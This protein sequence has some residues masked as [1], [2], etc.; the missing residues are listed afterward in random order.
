[1]NDILT[2]L[3]PDL[4]ELAWRQAQYPP[5][6]PAQCRRVAAEKKLRASLT[7][8]QWRLYLALEAEIN[9][10]MAMEEDCLLE[11]SLRLAQALYR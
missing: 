9:R 8:K 11:Q 10:Q 7:K 1:M 6:Y 2:Q 4:G 5:D 3:L